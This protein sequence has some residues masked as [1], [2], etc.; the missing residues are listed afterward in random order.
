MEWKLRIHHK[1]LKF[2]EELPESRKRIIREGIKELFEAF[3]NVD[4]DYK[5]GFYILELEWSFNV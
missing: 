4:K 2:F 3:K 5:L 1:A